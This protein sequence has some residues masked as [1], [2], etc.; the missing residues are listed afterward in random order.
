[1]F[2][3]QLG[4][5]LEAYVDDMVLKSAQLMNHIRDLEEVFLVIC[6]YCM[7]LN[8]KK[9]IIGIAT[10]KFLGYLVLARAIEA[11]VD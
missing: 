9:C 1:M 7:R 8:P 11:N 5:T 2:F 10:R 3:D 4:G 6:R